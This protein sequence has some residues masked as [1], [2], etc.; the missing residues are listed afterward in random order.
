MKDS[1]KGNKEIATSMENPDLD[2]R[3]VILRIANIDPAKYTR[4]NSLKKATTKEPK[5]IKVRSVIPRSKPKNNPGIYENSWGHAL[6]SFIKPWHLVTLILL[7]VIILS[8]L[9]ISDAIRSK[10]HIP[11]HCSIA[12]NSNGTYGKQ[13][14]YHDS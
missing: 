2:D 3:P 6:K 11:A 7:A 10:A 5:E 13:T 9:E 12:I 1:L 14:C 4:R 8:A